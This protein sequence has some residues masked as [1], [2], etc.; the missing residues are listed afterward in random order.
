MSACVWP[1]ASVNALLIGEHI[2]SHI[3]HQI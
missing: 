3:Q 1:N 2:C